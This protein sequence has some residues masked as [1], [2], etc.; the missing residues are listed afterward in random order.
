MIRRSRS[1]SS[2][3]SSVHLP[4]QPTK[5]PSK[6]QSQP[7]PIEVGGIGSSSSKITYMPPETAQGIFVNFKDLYYYNGNKLPFAAA[8]IGQDFRNEISPR[9]GLLRVREVT[10]V[11]IEHFVDPDDKSHPKFKEVADLEFLMFPREEQMT[12]KPAKKICLGEAVSNFVCLHFVVYLCFHLESRILILGTVNNQ[13]LG[14][15]IWR[16][17]LFLTHDLRA[18][19]GMNG[20]CILIEGSNMPCTPQAIDILRKAKVL[21]APTKVATA[22]GM[23]TEV[24]SWPYSFPNSEDFPTPEQQGSVSGRFLIRDRYIDDDHIS[25]TL[26]MLALPGEVGS[27]QRE[28]KGYQFWTRADTDGFFTISYIRTGDYNLYAWVPDFIGDYKN[29]GNITVTEG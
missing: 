14:Y 26:H 23:L 19:P 20:C 6:T 9:E 18:H 3:S 7:T 13:T 22:G 15:F 2:Q 25:A 17:Y 5:G 4:T 21:I 1:R 29:D 8:Q 10:L 16:V 27:W 12:G 11:E 24:E 28:R